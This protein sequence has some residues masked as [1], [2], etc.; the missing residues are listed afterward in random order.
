MEYVIVEFRNGDIV[1]Y[2]KP[3]QNKYTEM[4]ISVVD[5]DERGFKSMNITTNSIK[6]LESN[7]IEFHKFSDWEVKDYE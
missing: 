3:R 4:L 6:S 7:A 2:E 1:V 5:K